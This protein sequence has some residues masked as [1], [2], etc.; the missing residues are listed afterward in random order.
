MEVTLLQV[1][2]LTFAAAAIAALISGWTA[3]KAS[4]AISGGLGMV[5]SALGFTSGVLA[6]IHNSAFALV[7]PGLPWPMGALSFTVDPLA[8]FFIGL[9]CLGTTATS[10]YSLG[11]LRAE[12]IQRPVGVLGALYHL[13]ILSML[14]VVMAASAVSF[15]IFWECMALFSFGLVIFDNQSLASQKAGLQYLM[16]AHVGTAFLLVMYLLL[17]QQAG[18]MNFAQFAHAGAQ[19]PLALK[20][21]LFGCAVVGFGAKAGLVP[22]HTWLPEAHPAAPSHVSAMMSGLMLKT[23]VYG[24]LRCVFEFLQPFPMG[25]GITLVVISLLTAL[26]GITYASVEGNL[27]RLL[28]YSSIENMGLIFLA[29]GLAM[30]FTSQ[31]QPEWASLFLI[32]ALLHSLNHATFKSLLFLSAGAILSKTHTASLQNLGGLIHKMPLTAVLF[33][34]GAL[35]ISGLP[36]LNGFISEWMIFQGLVFSTQHAAESLR[37]FLP[38][39]AAGLGLTGA[40]VVATFVKAFASVF[41]AMPRS[42]HVNHATEV[43]PSMITGMGLC[44]L[45]C[46]VLGLAPGYLLPVLLRLSQHLLPDLAPTLAQGTLG[47]APL[48]DELAHH[49]TTIRLDGFATYTPV[50]VLLAVVFGLG[51]AWLLPQWLGKRTLTRR[52]L[53]WSCGV[54]P[55]AAFECSPRGFSQPLE[56]VFAKLHATTDS[57]AR[58]LYQPLVQGLMG[59]SRRVSVIQSGRIQ[60]YLA[61]SLCTLIACLLWLKQ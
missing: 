14:L 7:V 40:L 22:L 21:V 41:L 60:I 16:I 46:V 2:L 44:A 11:Y 10:V 24:F 53:T 30:V 50:F 18:G 31:H 17:A 19:L 23:A 43:S 58:F 8:G 39:C 56:L 6:L 42:H 26:L 15:L 37:I 47:R 38:L 32:A 12:F 25:W 3:P 5:A 45:L 54:T 9:I 35:A 33:L 59:L 1:A 27:K 51:A 55:E 57:Y 20:T 4:I 28:A 49:A 52:T 29:V 48:F 61:Y 36:P 34:I 13:F